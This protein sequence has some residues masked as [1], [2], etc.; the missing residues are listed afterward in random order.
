MQQL[1]TMLGPAVHRRIR[2]HPIRLWRPCVMIVR[3]PSKLE[4]PCK[5][6]QN[7]CPKCIEESRKNLQQV[8]ICQIYLSN[9][10]RSTIKNVFR[11]AYSFLFFILLCFQ[12]LVVLLHQ[13]YRCSTTFLKHSS[14]S[15]SDLRF[16]KNL[17]RISRSATKPLLYYLYFIS[18][19]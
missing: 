5:W 4:E 19:V 13:L 8:F 10:P 17:Y 18:I 1:P 3:G 14:N 15:Y 9:S 2:I 12:L 16:E 7:C 11:S 6:I